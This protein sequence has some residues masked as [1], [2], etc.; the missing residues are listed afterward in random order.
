MALVMVAS[1]MIHAVGYDAATQELEIVFN[2]GK[3]DCYTGVP[4]TV[5]ADLLVA[6]SKVSICGRVSSLD[7]P[8]S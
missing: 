3:T 2:S 7:T 5:S 4:Q 8:M 1:S 6:D